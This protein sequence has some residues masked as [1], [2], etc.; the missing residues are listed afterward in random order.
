MT[1]GESLFV[2]VV[3]ERDTKALI[4]LD[5]EWLD[6]EEV[7]MYNFITGY[8]KEYSKLPSMRLFR[9]KFSIKVTTVEDSADY[10]LDELRDRHTYITLADSFPKLIKDAKKE[11]IN[12][13][14]KMAEIIS[15]LRS[16]GKNAELTTY[17]EDTNT[18]IEDYEKRISARGIT[19]LP[20]GDAF[21]DSLTFGYKETD[22]ITIGGRPGTKKTWIIIYLAL[23]LDLVLDDYLKDRPILFVSN[24]IGVSELKDRMDCMRYKLCYT[25]FLKGNLDKRSKERYERGL[26]KT[27]KSHIKITTKC[28]QLSD[29]ELLVK[30]YKPSI[31]FVD[32]SYLME[33]KMSTGWEKITFITQNLK[34]IALQNG[35]PVINTTQSRRRSGGSGKSKGPKTALDAQDEFA[36]AD[37][38]SQDS[39]LAMIL[40]PDTN[41]AWSNTI[42]GMVA[43]GRSI[44]IEK[45]N[46]KVQA[47]LTTMDFKFEQNYDEKEEFEEEDADY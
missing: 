44:D 2:K 8:F 43:K 6:G 22:L 37:S 19:Y 5:P 47:S 3:S 28:R 39:D 17:G 1:A 34:A 13:L 29:L 16:T 12:V 10:Y 42:L 9:D 35:V 30:L 41:T 46:F 4:V 15:Q 18:R 20:S 38:Y 14:E 40:Y 25:D 33:P 26:K 36:F 24:E 32:G 21:L 11:S 27:E 23:I 45:S 31:I 7:A